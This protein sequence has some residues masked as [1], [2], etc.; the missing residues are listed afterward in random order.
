MLVLGEMLVL[1]QTLVLGTML[2]PRMMII[3]GLA[4]RIAGCVV[5]A[6]RIFILQGGEIEV[7]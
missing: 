5:K 3:A 7:G 1:G 2:A 4:V 6:N